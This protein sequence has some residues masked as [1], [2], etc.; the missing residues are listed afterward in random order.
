MTRIRHYR[1]LTLTLCLMWSTP[2]SK[3]GSP[4]PLCFFLT[5]L[6][7]LKIFI[8][9]VGH[10]PSRG[11]TSTRF[12]Q[13][14]YKNPTNSCSRIFWTS[15]MKMKDPKKSLVSHLS[16][17]ILRHWPP[18]PFRRLFTLS[19]MLSIKVSWTYRLRVVRVRIWPSRSALKK[20]QNHTEYV[21]KE[22]DK[23]GNV[24]LWLTDMYL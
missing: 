13:N 3:G 22:A 9:F 14:A 12:Y 19:L 7:C 20:L 17:H 2:F 21:I 8:S 5:S 16:D 11:F 18:C 4:F 23:G 24:V 15:W 1:L 6:F 10:W